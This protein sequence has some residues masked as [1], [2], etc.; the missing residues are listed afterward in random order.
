MLSVA[1][2]DHIITMDLHASQIQVGAEI[3]KCLSALSEPA[4]CLAG[5]LVIF[6]LAATAI[7]TGRDLRGQLGY[8][9]VSNRFIC[10]IKLQLFLISL[11]RMSP[12]CE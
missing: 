7:R 4:C 2:A 5:F 11:G 9:E 1:G 3:R 10:K 6:F 12:V 8:R